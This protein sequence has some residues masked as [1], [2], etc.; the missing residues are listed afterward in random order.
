MVLKQNYFR[1]LKKINKKKNQNTTQVNMRMGQDKG[2]QNPLGI[3]ETH[4]V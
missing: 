1:P 4:R 3:P 2:A